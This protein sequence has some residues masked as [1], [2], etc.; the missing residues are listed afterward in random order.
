MIANLEALG[1][2]AET[3]TMTRAATSLRITQSAVSKRIA[4]LEAETGQKLI[5]PLGRRVRLTPAGVRLLEKTQPFLTGLR[6]AIAGD[7]PTRGGRIVIGI[8]E[9]ILCSWGP[10][11]LAQ[12]RATIP[13]LE[14]TVNTHR[15]PVVIDQVRSG[16]YMLALCTSEQRDAPDL[17][18][19]LLYEEPM[20]IVPSRL[21]FVDLSAQHALPVIT[22]EPHSITWR[23]LA[24]RLRDQA[25]SWPFK[26]EVVQT[27]QSFA[28]IAQ[29]ARAG[30]GHGLVPIGV[31]QA[32]A[33]PPEALIH[34]PKPGLTRPISLVGRSATLANPLIKTF[35]HAL[36][37]YFK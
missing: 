20:V 18:A 5:E 22:I 30:L 24:R 37:E 28:S 32:L 8:S 29:M 27:V 2:L 10:N 31:A 23:C 17:K 35:H 4:T 21:K 1:A 19:E 11:L 36:A 6:D 12:V 26:L 7:S 33:V 34:F 9:S 13:D 3:G 15:S 16:E 14:F 25:S